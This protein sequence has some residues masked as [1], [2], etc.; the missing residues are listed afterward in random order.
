MNKIIATISLY[1]LAFILSVLILIH[2]WGLEPKS[3]WWIIGGGVII[4]ILLEAML[5]ISKEEK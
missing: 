3:W 4:K 5:T 1:I 2:G